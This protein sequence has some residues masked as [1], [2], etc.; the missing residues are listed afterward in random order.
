[1]GNLSSACR[2][3]RDD[4]NDAGKPQIRITLIPTDH[5]DH[6]DY[7][8][9]QLP[10]E[11]HPPLSPLPSLLPVYSTNSPPPYVDPPRYSQI[12]RSETRARRVLAMEVRERDRERV[13]Q[14]E[15]R[16]PQS[17]PGSRTRTMRPWLRQSVR[18]DLRAMA[19]H[20]Y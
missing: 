14:R 10:I 12:D 7:E 5:P 8:L 15:I 17:E 3:I 4:F 9:P 16:R 18:A 11:R 6:P 1:M 13:R 19:M 20:D 2:K